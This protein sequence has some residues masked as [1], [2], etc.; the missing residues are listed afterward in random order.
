M[1]GPGYSGDKASGKVVDVEVDLADDFH[2]YAVEWTPNKISWYFDDNCYA[3]S[4]PDVVAPN[5]WVYNKPFYL[6]TNLAMGGNFTGP[7]DP[8]L[9]HAQ[10]E[11]DYIR[12]Y[13]IDGIGANL[14]Y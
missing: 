3:T 14:L 9:Q 11:I 2:I 4:T 12:H 7:L 10:L 6:I 1:H 13:S 5:E 8:D